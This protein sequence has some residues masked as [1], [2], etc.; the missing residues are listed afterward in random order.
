MTSDGI[1]DEDWSRV[2]ELAV[3]IANASMKDESAT[4]ARA[5]AALFTLLD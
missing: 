4:P 2:H 3:A 5:R 1:T